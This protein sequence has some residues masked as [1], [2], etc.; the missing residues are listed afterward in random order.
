MTGFDN[1]GLLARAASRL[2][3]VRMR[4]WLILGAVMLGFFAL[5]IWAGIALMSWLWGQAPAATEAG[6]RLTG[7]AVT[8]VEQVA[9]GVRDQVEQ[10]VPGLK[11]QLEKWVPGLAGEPPASDVSGTDA[12]PVPR[13]PGLARSYFARDGN[14]QEVR[15]TGRAVLDGVLTHYVQGF[16]AAGYTQQVISASPDGEQHRFALGQDVILLSLLRRPGGLVDVGLK[17]SSP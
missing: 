10:W 5:V 11:G 4:T 14:T 15:Y 13:Y 6:K 8:Q 7:A 3:R 9:P 17:I 2:K 12:G 16:T 1:Y